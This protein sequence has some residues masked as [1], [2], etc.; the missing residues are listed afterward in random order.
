MCV[1]VHVG[2]CVFII[3]CDSLSSYQQ[4]SF[5]KGSECVLCH[6]KNVK[7]GKE[8]NNRNLCIN[9]L[10]LHFAYT[11]LGSNIKYDSRTPR[12]QPLRGF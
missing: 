6:K 3:L 12:R 8:N 4:Y 7:F 1:C 5:I 9:I 10:C 2:L 11:E